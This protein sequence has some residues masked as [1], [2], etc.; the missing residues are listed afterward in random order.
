WTQYG[1]PEL[2]PDD[3]ATAVYLFDERGGSVV[4]N[5]MKQGNDLVIPRSYQV[6]G[7]VALEPFWKEFNFSSSYWKGNLKNVIGFVPT[8]FCFCAYFGG[9]VKRPAAITVA[10]G[11][12]VSLAIELLQI[13]LPTRDSGS[14]DLITNT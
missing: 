9:S 13:V 3:R 11:A 12:L 7:K 14:T 8:G 1:R 10:F 2:T 4:H 5:R 6:V